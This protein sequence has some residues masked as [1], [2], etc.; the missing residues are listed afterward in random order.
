M[1]RVDFPAWCEGI[2]KGRSYVSD[3]Y[4][5]ALQFTVDGKPP[6]DKLKLA[7]AGKVDGEGEGRVRA[8]TPRSARP[9]AATCPRATP[10]LSS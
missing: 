10:A 4:A 5:H 3:G 1:D 6:G 9:W 2:G 8:G 7:A